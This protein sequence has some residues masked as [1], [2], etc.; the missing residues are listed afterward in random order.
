[1]PVGRRVAYWRGRRKLSQQVFADRL[2][3][4][5]SWV[6]K[7][8][9]GVRSLDKLSTLQEIARVLRIDTAALVGRDVEATQATKRGDGV[10]R[11]RAALSRY[12]IPLGKPVVRQVLPVD[13]MLRDV[14]YAWTTFQYARYPQLVDLAPDLLTNAQRTHA[15]D[16]GSGRVPLVEA[17]RIIAA[18]LVK[19]GDA[20]LAW[21]AVDRA[22]LAATGDRNLVA[23]AAVQL[24]QVLRALGRAREAKS[25]ML[26]AAYRIAPPVIEHG[27]PA[28]LSLCGTLLIQAALAAAQDGN[29]ATASELIDE[30]A[31]MAERVGDGYDHH[32]TGFGPTAVDL[33]RTAIAAEAG[34]ARDAIVW[35]EKATKRLGW[36]GLPAE[37]R[38][39][40]LLDVARAYLH[41]GDAG[42]AARVLTEAERTAPAEIM[43]RPVARDVLAEVARDPR[44]TTAP[45][46]SSRSRGGFSDDRERVLDHLSA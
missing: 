10:D 33:A 36:R 34:D 18:L 6:D 46:R 14:G 8:E 31:G 21:L 37:H 2:G 11:I 30:A 27:T 39:A 41:A 28:Q 24:G 42:N 44:A 19:L 16:P 26:S 38:A 15:I 45:P 32:R 43:Y 40:H 22:M 20:E 17:Y 3:K 5:K 9:R 25:V 12:D 1:M 35:H 29:E 7:V 23:A 4:S 13:R